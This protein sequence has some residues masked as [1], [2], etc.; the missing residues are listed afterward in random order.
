MLKTI[1]REKI[2]IQEPFSKKQM[3][4]FNEKVPQI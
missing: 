4:F 2:V 1:Q 3:Q